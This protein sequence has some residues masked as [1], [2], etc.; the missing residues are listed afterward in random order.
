MKS[1]TRKKEILDVF[2]QLVQRFGVDKTTMH[3]VARELKMSIGLLYIEFSGKDDLVEGLFDRIHFEIINF[4]SIHNFDELSVEEKLKAVLVTKISQLSLNARRS[5]AI[6][7]FMSGVVPT[8]YL[9]KKIDAK[10][11]KIQEELITKIEQ[12]LV[13]GVQEN[14]FKINDIPQTAKILFDAFD[15]Y[16]FPPRMMER[17]H[18]VFMIDV[19]KMFELIMKAL[20]ST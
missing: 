13:L 19:E 9:R 7:D 17:E 11:H 14:K 6:F 16:R 18:D 8:K 20:R 4:N 2:E 5:K 10:M 12:I 15:S 1:E 3:D